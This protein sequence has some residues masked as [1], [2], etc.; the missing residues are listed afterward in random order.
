M[1]AAEKEAE[2]QKRFTRAV[3]SNGIEAMVDDCHGASKRAGWYTDR[4]TGKPI[5][6]NPAEM[7]ALMHSELSE[8]LEAV[9]KGG[10]DSHLPHRPA[11][12]VEAADLLIRLLDYVG[13]RKLDIVGAY[14]EKRVYNDTRADHRLENRR[15]E[16][17][18]AF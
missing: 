3:I 11:E 15:K 5:E 8:M 7:I 18:K 4:H 13:Y 16:G 10:F 12:E 9:R 2:A 1:N 14:L 6:R 17:G